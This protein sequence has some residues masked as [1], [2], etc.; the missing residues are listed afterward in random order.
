MKILYQGAKKD[1]EEVK[2]ELHDGNFE[3]VLFGEDF[4]LKK[5]SFLNDTLIGEKDGGFSIINH[6]EI[7]FIEA[8]GNEVIC[9]TITDS[10]KIKEKLY[11]IESIFKT[12]GFIRTSK[13][14]VVNKKHIKKIIPEF[15]R[16]FTLKLSNGVKIIVSRRYFTDFKEA[17]GMKVKI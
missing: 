10:Y 6:N 9:H 12:F 3:F 4:V 14:Y 11:E 16:K 1:I 13:C 15:N 2:K 17:I 7:I 5:S 8:Y